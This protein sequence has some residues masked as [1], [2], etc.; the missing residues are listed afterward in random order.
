MI[1]ALD[2]ESLRRHQHIGI[3]EAVGRLELVARELDLESVRV[4]QVDRVHEPAI[5]LQKLDLTFAQTSGYLREGG[6]RDVERDVLHAPDLARRG[7]A[8]VVPGLVR[9]H[10]EQTSIAGVEVE[11]VLIWLAEIRLL[12]DERHA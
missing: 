6:S 5:A 3:T 9:E 8:S 4:L 12:H 2:T 7:A 11:M 1:A 10:G